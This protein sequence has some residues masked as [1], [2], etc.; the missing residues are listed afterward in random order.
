MERDDMKRRSFIALAAGATAMPLLSLRSVHAQQP[1]MPTVGLLLGGT[2]QADA[3]RVNAIRQGLKETGFIEGQNVAIEYR[4]AENR[5]DRLQALAADLVRRRVTVIGA[6][7]NAAS[8]VAK[9]ATTTIPIVFEVGNDP[10]EFGLVK[11]LARP[12]GNLTGV[13]FLGGSLTPKQFEV[14]H[15]TVPKTSIIGMIENPSNP[16]TEEVR[17]NV[18]AAAE[19]LGRE[20]IFAQAVVESDIEQAVASLVQRRAGALLVRSDVLF[21]GRPNLLVGLA[22]RHALPAIYPLRDFAVA[23]GLMSYGASLRDALRQ[24]G[25]YIGRVLKGETPADLPVMQ[26]AKIELIINMKTATALGITFPLAL[27][28]RAD[29]VIE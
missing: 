1:T 11:S 24:T 23:G 18:R 10:I 22:A 2:P 8:R 25:V 27:L 6:I 13:T 9:E 26:S 28:G 17:R 15:E 20:L 16:N 7:G 29:E 19:A 12:D 3:F 4:W 14:L 21:N 5:Y